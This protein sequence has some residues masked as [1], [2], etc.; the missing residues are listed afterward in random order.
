[1]RTFAQGEEVFL[2]TRKYGARHAIVPDGSPYPIRRATDEDGLE[3]L[4]DGDED[5]F[6]KGR[7]LMEIV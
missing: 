5:R 4:S 7:T 6:R 3:V 2:H 1:V